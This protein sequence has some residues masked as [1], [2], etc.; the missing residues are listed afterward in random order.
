MMQRNMT[1]RRW[2]GSVRR[3]IIDKA[4][5]IVLYKGYVNVYVRGA[6]IEG[7]LL[8]QIIRYIDPLS[9]VLSFPP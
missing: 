2:W 4:F 9:Q 5:Y 6:Y 7:G 8:C 3:Y 1:Y